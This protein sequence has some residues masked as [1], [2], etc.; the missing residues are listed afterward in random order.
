LEN[1]SISPEGD[2]GK[3]FPNADKINGMDDF[4]KIRIYMM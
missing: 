1:F 2:Q 4:S 3:Y